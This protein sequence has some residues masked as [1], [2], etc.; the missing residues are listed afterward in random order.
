MAKR[1]KIPDINIL[2]SKIRYNPDTGQ[3]FW[4]C[5]KNAGKLA[6]IIHNKRNV[7][8]FSIMGKQRYIYASRLAWKITTGNDPVEY[9]DH[10]NEDKLDDRFCNL[11]EA[12][13]SENLCNIKICTRTSG[14]YKGVY[15]R[16]GRK[17]KLITKWVYQISLNNKQYT[18]SGFKSAIEAHE[19]RCV[20]GQQLHGEYFSYKEVSFGA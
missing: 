15:Q 20:F 4:N 13:H 18:V 3:F 9:I 1:H 8:S 7:I 10:I 14:Q 11:R 16:V 6:T 19:A 17:G 2:N 12:N 5:G